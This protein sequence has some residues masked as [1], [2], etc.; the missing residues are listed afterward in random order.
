MAAAGNMGAQIGATTTPIGHVVVIFDENI[1]IDTTI[2]NGA[3]VY[4]G[5]ANISD[6]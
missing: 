6:F 4:S 5:R 1:S 3:I 2:V